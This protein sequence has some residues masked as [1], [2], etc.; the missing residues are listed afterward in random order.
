MGLFN[1]SKKTIFSRQKG[2]QRGA[3]DQLEW[4]RLRVEALG[5]YM[6]DN[7]PESPALKGRAGSLPLPVIRDILLPMNLC[8]LAAGS[9]LG[10]QSSASVT[11]WPMKLWITKAFHLLKIFIY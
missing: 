9:V 6:V 11:T 4:Q 1:H 8:S 2:E 3:C 10:F 7:D 5:F